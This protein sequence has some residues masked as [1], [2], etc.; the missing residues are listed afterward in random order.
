MDPKEPRT[1]REGRPLLQAAA[2]IEHASPE[3]APELI[4]RLQ[5]WLYGR[6]SEE[7][8]EASVERAIRAGGGPVE[9]LQPLRSRTA[10][11]AD[12]S[13]QD[14]ARSIGESVRFG[15]Y[16]RWEELSR[17]SPPPQS[18]IDA[19]TSALASTL[20]ATL[21]DKPSRAR[22]PTK[23]KA[24][25]WASWPAA[26][27]QR[28]LWNAEPSDEAWRRLASVL[29]RLDA[30]LVEGVQMLDS[31]GSSST[32]LWRSFVRSLEARKLGG[33]AMLARQCA[34]QRWWLVLIGGK[35]EMDRLRVALALVPIWSQEREGV[36]ELS[37]RKLSL[38][39]IE[40]GSTI[41]VRADALAALPREEQRVLRDHDWFH[42]VVSARTA[43]EVL[44]L[45][46]APDLIEGLY[47][48]LFDAPW[49]LPP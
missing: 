21:G 13:W 24:I 49:F 31:S 18:A 8:L 47:P 37:R 23:R 2:A 33:L 30:L 20:R 26:A 4:A 48:R 34:R 36:V 14:F 39:R 35:S 11:H 7:V 29:E 46:S 42:V 19:F 25:R 15:D 43:S 9:S 12:A 5:R 40:H 6:A 22:R 27:L 17:A 1:S 45:E 3:E 32:G 16:V 28:I 41:F 38:D 10:R 44:G